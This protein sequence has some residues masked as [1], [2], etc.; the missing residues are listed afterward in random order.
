MTS[1]IFYISKN[2]ILGVTP[3]LREKVTSDVPI[4]YFNSCMP[5]AANVQIL[6]FPFSQ[7]LYLII[8]WTF[9]LRCV[10]GA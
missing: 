4:V 8:N 2:V 9:Q 6:F 10:A 3:S 7:P 1:K 5:G